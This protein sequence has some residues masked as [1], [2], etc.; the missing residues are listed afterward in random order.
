MDDSGSLAALASHTSE[1]DR[2]QGPQIEHGVVPRMLHSRAEGET[3]QDFYARM[4]RQGG[5]AYAYDPQTAPPDYQSTAT[6]A[7]LPDG[8]VTRSDVRGSY[9]L[10]RDAERVRSTGADQLFLFFLDEGTLCFH[11]SGDEA[12]T[13][14]QPVRPGD[15]LIVDLARPFRLKMSSHA[16]SSLVIG[17]ALLPEG[18][19][20]C[21]LHGCVAPAA[22]PL[23]PVVIEMVRSLCAGCATMKPA[24]ATAVLRAAVDLL[25]L[26]LLD[27]VD[28][29]SSRMTLKASVEVLIDI[30]LSNTKLSPTWIA[31]KLNVSRATLYRA[32]S[33]YGG[34]TTLINDRRMQRAWELLSS[35]LSETALANSCGFR[36]RAGFNSAFLR[37]YG[38]ERQAARRLQGSEL[39]S[40]KV[41]VG[42]GI[43]DNWGKLTK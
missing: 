5:F 23:A 15:I 16:M 11:P 18:V 37:T 28:Q 40:V 35:D 43:I 34:V 41:K 17:R 14:G 12:S 33:G 26:A 38:I 29:A 19:R 13:L 24:Q 22:H 4:S 6:S 30:H 7:F 42:R 20:A 36:S 2:P 9:A 31:Q 25:G 8:V 3:L 32:L 10:V 27:V 1:V 39:E 21:A